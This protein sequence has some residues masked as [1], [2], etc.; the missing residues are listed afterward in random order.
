MIEDPEIGRI[1]GQ[2][3]CAACQ[4]TWGS[5]NRTRC[6]LHLEGR[7]PVICLPASSPN[8]ATNAA[9]ALPE[10]Q[11]VLVAPPPI[12]STAVPVPAAPTPASAQATAPVILLTKKNGCYEST[13]CQC[14]T[15]EMPTRHRC[16]QLLQNGPME[17][18]EIG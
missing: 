11:V 14:R 6:N 12:S 17:D 10:A 8:P 1:C 13:K 7:P 3:F 15:R 2:A 16:R 9:P 18:P 5:E 4:E